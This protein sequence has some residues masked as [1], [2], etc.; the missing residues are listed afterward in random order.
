ME[1]PFENQLGEQWQQKPFCH[2]ISFPPKIGGSLGI[3]I[4]QLLLLL[5]INEKSLFQRN[6]LCKRDQP[7]NQSKPTKQT[8]NQ[9]KT[10]HNYLVVEP[11]HLKKCATV[12][13]DPSSPRIG[14]KIKTFLKPPT[15]K[16]Q[17]QP[18]KPNQ[19][20]GCFRKKRYPRI[21]HFNRVFHC[22]PSIFGY[23]YFWK[24][25]RFTSFNSEDSELSFLQLISQVLQ[26][27]HLRGLQ[28]L[29]GLFDA[30]AGIINITKNRWRKTHQS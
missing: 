29:Q 13:L 9:N 30:G 27:S 28:K 16:H 15:R 3:L 26:L 22:K 8:N 1:C 25:P 4:L 5:Q 12:K 17:T 18:T 19:V 20:H 24:H 10:K 7:T 14:V 21:I 6:S 2:S 23:P 11:T